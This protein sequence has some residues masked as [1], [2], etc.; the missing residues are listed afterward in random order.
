M[1]VQKLAVWVLLAIS[2]ANAITDEQGPLGRLSTAVINAAGLLTRFLPRY[3][4]QQGYTIEENE[5]DFIIVGSGPTGAAL[6]NRLSEEKAWKILLLEAGDEASPITEVPFLC[7]AL[8][9]SKYNWGYKAEK[10]D[11]FCKGCIDGRMEWPHGKSLG[12]STI[13]N[14]MIYVRGN[15]LDYDR[16]EAMGNPGWSYKDIFPYFLK[17]EDAHITQT[18][19]DA[20]YHGKGG[21][22]G[23]S[24]VTF[25]SGAVQEGLWCGVCQEWEK[26][27]STCQERSIPV[28]KDLPVGEKMYDHAT[29]VGM[30]FTV[31]QSIVLKI[32]DYVT[33]PESYAAFLKRGAGPFTQIGGVEALTY[34]K[35]N[36]SDDPDPTFPDIELIFVGGALSTDAGV[37]YRR[38]FNIPRRTYDIIWKPLEGKPAF[39]VYPMLFHPKSTGYIRLRSRN[40]LEPPKFYPNYFSDPQN[41]DIKTMIAA[42]REVQRIV[43]SPAMQKFGAKIVA[44]CKMG[45][46]EDKE[47]IVDARLRVHG[48]KGLRVA[49]TSVIPLPVTA[50]T[51]EPAYVVGEK[52]ADL[53]KQ[54]WGM[55]LV[56]ILATIVSTILSS[57]PT[58]DQ[59]P[60]RNIATGVVNG[61]ATL[62]NTVSEQFDFII[63]GASPSGSVLANRLSEIEGWSVLLLEAGGEPSLLTR[64]APA[65]SI[66]SST[67][68]DWGY[69]AE[70]QDSFC[71]GCIRR[72]VKLPRGKCLGGGS[73]TNYMIYT[74]GNKL[75]YDLWEAEGNPG[76]SYKDVL[77]YFL[78][79]EDANIKINDSGYHNK[80]G[81]LGVSDVPHRTKSAGVFVKAAE[82]AGYPYVDN[83]GER[84]IGTS[85]VQATMRNGL[86]SSAE[87]SFLR[88]VRHRKNLTIR[89][90]AHVTKVLINLGKK[91]AYGV[92]YMKNKE[93]YRAFCRKEVIVS[94]GSLNSPQ[95]LMLSGIGPKDQLEQ[96][97]MGFLVNESITL[98]LG[99]DLFKPQTY[100]DLLFHGKG[101][102]TDLG[103]TNSLVWLKTNLTDQDHPSLPDV[104]LIFAP[105]YPGVDFGLFYRINFNIGDEIYNTVWK[106]FIGKSVFQ[107]IPML[108][109]P[110]S[111]GR[112]QLRSKDPFEAPKYFENFFSDPENLDVKRIIVAIR[113]IQRI[114]D[115]PALQKYAAKLI[116]IPIPEND[117]QAVVDSNLRV[118]GLKSLRIV[119]M[120][121]VPRPISGHT[122]APA[123]MIGEKGA[124][125]IKRDWGALPHI[126]NVRDTPHD[127]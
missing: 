54:D 93:I 26:V 57:I 107:L 63:V 60:L 29:F 15:R 34:I 105:G 80:G 74:R 83:N 81:P 43:A 39:Q 67:E 89:R 86:R 20:G 75:D 49:D 17:S 115:Q 46:A 66:L 98:N 55:S 6:A 126:I 123:Y 102:L 47:A 2:Y 99:E 1:L 10:M 61:S 13:I 40:P 16:W 92:E 52:G 94:A 5:F 3:P 9:F 109:H 32:Q 21:Y 87:T 120:S 113:E 76:W 62:R 8:E 121:V 4:N 122:V 88:P 23:V 127:A 51:A 18:V 72:Q 124:D 111:K 95:L 77:P 36:A 22:L 79:S 35:T 73:S 50:H 42:I 45:P 71:S 114:A 106:P 101:P 85:Y 97:G 112:M 82:E 48:T 11:G 19:Q 119:D 64:I 125:I 33:S 12:G 65:I 56:H 31:N 7:G 118:H 38:L 28:I 53:I 59:E 37:V 78:K 44:T 27:Q 58:K 30:T 96:L 91:E 14:Y 41:H 90:G 24:D 104:E 84:E 70:Q 117:K 68:Y 100:T 69:Y 108:M 116:D 103:A 110:R 25:R